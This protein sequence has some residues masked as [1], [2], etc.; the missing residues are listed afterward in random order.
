MHIVHISS[1]RGVATALEAR[2][3]GT[4][5]SLETCPHYLLFTEED[6]LRIGAPAK[7]APPLRKRSE[8]DALWAAVLGGEIDVIGSDHSPCPPEMK[9]RENVFEIW[10]GIA[11][12]QW[13]L[14]ALLSAGMDKGLDLSLLAALT[15]SNGARRFRI[16]RRG[17]IEPGAYADLVLVDLKASQIVSED[18]LFQRHKIT[19]IPWDETPRRRKENPYAGVK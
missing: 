16:E 6:L 5:I 19:P 17:A 4:D 18:L 1:G 10:G 7:C 13:T 11:G 3:L 9:R 2:A 15:S 14:P 12:V 8:Q